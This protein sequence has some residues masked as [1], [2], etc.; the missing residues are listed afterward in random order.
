LRAGFV[1]TPMSFP[2]SLVRSFLARL[3]FAIFLPVT[4]RLA[5]QTAVQTI[6]FELPARVPVNTTSIALSASA[7]SGLPVTFSILSGP[8]SIDGNR[9]LVSGTGQIV[10]DA[11]Q[12][13]DATFLPAETNRTVLVAD[14][15]TL[16]SQPQALTVAKGQAFSLQVAV[17]GT[18]PLTYQWQRNEN[19][20]TTT[21]ILQVANATTNLTGLYYVIVRNAAGAVTSDVVSVTVDLP[22]NE[23]SLR[24]RGAVAGFPLGSG[25]GAPIRIQ[26]RGD[27]A[28]VADGWGK[29]L[30]VVDVHDP[31]HPGMVAQVPVIGSFGFAFGVA[32]IDDF[33]ITA[34]RGD[35]LGIIDIHEPTA[36][37][38]IANFKLPGSL[39]N[40]IVIRGRTGYVGDEDGGLVIVDLSRP[41]RPSILASIRPPI[42]PGGPPF[43]TA[44]GVQ[45]DG[46][47]AYIA[48]W[49]GGVSVVDI[50][51]LSLPLPLQ[52]VAYGAGNARAFD[53]LP[54]GSLAYVADIGKGLLVVDPAL[55]TVTPVG[56]LPGPPWELK[57]AGDSLFVANESGLVRVF[58]IRNPAKPSE[59]GGYRAQK[60][61]LGL[62]ARGNRLLLGG[63]SLSVLDL[64]FANKP[65]AI[66]GTTEDRQVELGT[67]VSLDG[68]AMGA[69]P[70]SYR[71][72]HDGTELP[73]RSSPQ[74]S[75]T[76][77]SSADLGTYSVIVS[78][79]FGT[80]TNVA[81]KLSVGR[82][83][84]TVTWETPKSGSPLFVGQ[85]Y[86]LTAT[87]F[88]GRPVDFALDAGG[89]TLAGNR[90]SP[91]SAGTVVLRAVVAGDDQRRPAAA[92]QTFTVL[93][94]PKILTSTVRFADGGV[95]FQVQVPP[96][97]AFAVLYADGLGGWQELTVGTGNQNPIDI[98]DSHVAG[99]TRFYR[100]QLK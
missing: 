1:I 4:V 66:T 10:V 17:A 83:S 71:W 68:A 34:E 45:V 33:A 86:E 74:L 62:L 53:V 70:M 22:G 28:Y 43:R 75:L 84:D 69:E 89:A 9:L 5:A 88:S 54:I 99:A 7:S 55:S 49:V 96:D 36:P 39:A 32:L 92:A 48:N 27:Y 15:P 51:D 87:T 60:T 19:S 76:N 61:L 82:P 46:N 78:N 67:N 24:P 20:A 98:T 6:A 13:G 40:S 8:G 25:S 23:F 64:S 35:D 58:D 41:E 79:A 90:L 57:R 37:V 31:D 100:V 50:T 11:V 77:L 63:G 72:L 29:S 16:L 2:R 73:D 47:R 18:E 95:R 26:L 56:K 91:T 97:F 14:P 3:C 94:A 30:Y 42:P 85:T 93:D 21:P 65:P 44:N 52:T 59:L 12:A 38:R 81:T 80:A